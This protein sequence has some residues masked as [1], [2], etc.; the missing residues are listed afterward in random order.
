MS[1]LEVADLSVRYEPR[2]Q[3]PHD[4]V[5]SVSFSI[6][7]G[8]FVG[9]VGESGSG[10]STLGNAILR[11][12]T[13]PARI[14]GGSVVF[15]GVDVAGLDGEALRRLR[16]VD[17]STVF[18]SS[19]NSLNPVIRVLETF[20]E[21]YDA[22]GV[23][24]S[25]RGAR[26]RDLL[27]LVS[28]DE[29]VLQAYP[30]ELSGGM[31]QR[32]ALALAL[33]L[34]PKLVV[35]DE[36]TTGLD[37]LVQRS[38]LDQVRHLQTQFGF[39]VIYISHDIGSV[40]EVSDRVLV[41]YDGEIVEDASASTLLRQPAHSYTDHLLGSY[42][43]AHGGVAKPL[44][45]PAAPHPEP[46]GP[47]PEPT[48]PHPEPTGP[49]PELVEG[50]PPDPT[51]LKIENLTKQYTTRRGRSR[52]SV[53]A[54]DNVSL[55]LQRG[56]VTALVGQSGSGK[57]TLARIMIG[58][59]RPDSGSVITDGTRVETLRGRQLKAYRQR[60]Q[61]VFQDP[62][63]ALNPT[64]SVGYALSRPLINY[65]GLRGSD[66]RGRALELL[67]QVGLTPASRFIDKLPHELSGG[68]RQRVVIARA[69]APDP[70]I[71][72]A[73]EPVSSLDVSIRAEILE[74]L[75]NLVADRELAMLYITHDLLSAKALADD[76]IVL[77][78]GKIVEHGPASEVIDH[79]KDAYTKELLGAIPNPY[80][81]GG[82]T[83]HA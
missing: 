22:H 37:V 35:L 51:V 76:V 65:A 81:S 40:L 68:Q 62:Y 43:A 1:L 61:Y 18:Q 53:Q 15:D 10:K 78:K 44:P 39:A 32:V 42:R 58:I 79:P 14:T 33:A 56:R 19:M 46:T 80:A 5:K 4:A 3:P 13:R 23:V 8:E 55:T 47:H 21:T 34:Q 24:E 59:E 26:T 45:E 17:L 20:N 73:D 16:W 25:D 36:P 41:M 83:R 74:L 2:Y 54:L 67:E 69:L 9:L 6:E 49:H 71:L 82:V 31:K 29:R 66:V 11:L 70:A 27:Q 28:L 48:G 7:P 75:R 77:S 57:S 12:I 63:S 30:H 72:I 50:P 64:T 60:T 52:S 38:I